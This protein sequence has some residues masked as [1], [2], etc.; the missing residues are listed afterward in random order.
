MKSR[1]ANYDLLTIKVAPMVCRDE[2]YD[3]AEMFRTFV[4]QLVIRA[5][6]E[7]ECYPFYWKT[8]STHTR[9]LLDEVC[10][11]KINLDYEGVP[12]GNGIF[13]FRAHFII[14]HDEIGVRSKDMAIFPMDADKINSIGYMSHIRW[15][16]E[17]ILSLSEYRHVHLPEQV[18]SVI[19]RYI[20]LCNLYEE[21]VRGW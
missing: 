2:V 15:I 18:K 21:V 10:E 19:F 8:L 14:M 13:V 6:V 11:Y 5:V 20:S 17:R 3:D 7:L 9:K 12:Y 1:E 4:D 16:C